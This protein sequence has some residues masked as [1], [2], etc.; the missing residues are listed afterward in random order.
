VISS[1]AINTV[2]GSTPIGRLSLAASLTHANLA[3][4][5]DL[6]AAPAEKQL[7]A[8][9]GTAGFLNLLAYS[10]NGLTRTTSYTSAS[11]SIPGSP[12]NPFAGSV[13]LALAP[14]GEHLLSVQRSSGMLLSL[15]RDVSSGGLE[16]DDLLRSG[17]PAGSHLG[18]AP[19]CRCRGQQRRTSRV[20]GVG[21]HQHTATDGICATGTRSAV[22]IHRTGSPGDR[23]RWWHAAGLTAVADVVGSVDGGPR[24]CDRL[25]GQRA[26]CLH[27]QQHQ[28]LHG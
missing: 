13:H 3:R 6:V 2:A 12:P 7:Y 24:V 11:L 1:F 16:Y 19:C 8:A 15:R 22:R 21:K 27:P 28:W 5:T 26:R 25:A 9:A 10:P 17:I 23:C 20:R 4:H 18:L 14:D